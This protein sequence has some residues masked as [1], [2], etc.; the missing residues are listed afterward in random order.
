MNE[1][2]KLTLQL[3]RAYREELQYIQNWNRDEVLI[4]SPVYFKI[5]DLTAD[6]ISLLGITEATRLAEQAYQFAAEREKV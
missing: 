4:L 6:L 2:E 1:V 3:E 5:R